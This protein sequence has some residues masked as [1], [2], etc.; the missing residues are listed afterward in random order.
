MGNMIINNKEMILNRIK[1]K[2]L[3]DS[4]GMDYV[5]LHDK[6]ES[7]YGLNLT[8]K[9]FM[10]NISNNYTWKLLYAHAIADVLNVGIYDLFDIV[11]VDIE[12][13]K[14]KKEQWKKKYQKKKG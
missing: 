8:Y 1:L 12:K 13:R 2:D 9:S 10:S 7:A 3:L 6:V 11:D 4:K 5:S 14:Q